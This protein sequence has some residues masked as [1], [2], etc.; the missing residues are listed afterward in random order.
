MVSSS[1]QTQ[2]LKNSYH[3]TTKINLLISEPS[4]SYKKNRTLKSS[5]C[6]RDNTWPISFDR[7]PNAPIWNI[8]GRF[9][10]MDWRSGTSSKRY[11]YTRVV[12][13]LPRRLR[14]QIHFWANHF[15]KMQLPLKMRKIMHGQ[16]RNICARKS[17][18]K[19]HNS[20]VWIYFKTRTT[21]CCKIVK[22]S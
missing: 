11:C 10:S 14:F 21:N 16:V 3:M 18:P 4:K 8:W 7:I 15:N 17:S 2:P 12:R 9:L 13:V 22:P 20:I 5:F 19:S 6:F 1:F